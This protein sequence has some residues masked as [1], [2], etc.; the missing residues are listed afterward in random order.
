MASFLFEFLMK[1]YQDMIGKY[2]SGIWT[3][4]DGKGKVLNEE[5]FNALYE[6]IINL[7]LNML[8]VIELQ[9]AIITLRRP[10][11]T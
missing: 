3:K 11:L 1:I 9:V 8:Q 5:F 4:P 7:D 10:L 2:M 6:L